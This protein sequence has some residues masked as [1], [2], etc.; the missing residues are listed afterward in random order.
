MKHQHICLWR[1]AYFFDNP[2]RRL[3]HNPAKMFG[4]YISSG[5]NA[6]DIGCGMGYFSI[7]I[8]KLVGQN[9]KVI[10]VD[11]QQEM[12]NILAKRA[13]RAGVKDWI[14]PHRCTADDLGINTR[15]NF[16]LTFW[17]VHEVPDLKKFLEQLKP[18]LLSDGHLF[19]A[20]PKM[21]VTEMKFEQMIALAEKTGWK[22]V[23]KPRVKLSRSVVLRIEQS[24]AENR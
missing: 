14:V 16:I 10:A 19:I 12:L 24:E 22:V 6:L 8:A 4:S 2:L 5:M 11:L 13:E 23:E 1:C 15:V 3:V 18:L 21:H 17:M 9:G 20:E 7:G